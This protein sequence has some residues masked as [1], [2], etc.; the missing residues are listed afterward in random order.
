MPDGAINVVLCF[1][2]FFA[3]SGEA[4]QGTIGVL[5]SIIFQGEKDVS[6]GKYEQA[7]QALSGVIANARSNPAARPELRKALN[8]LAVAY[9]ELQRLSD[10]RAL[11]KEALTTSEQIAD[12]RMQIAVLNNLGLVLQL[13][14]SVAEADRTFQKSLL[15][16]RS[17]P[18]LK[19]SLLYAK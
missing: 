16:A 18:G 13:Q 3:T 10:A 4:A 11:L 12:S 9:R 8:D 15:K 6:A 19:Q 7:A 2:F 5:R 14:G 17:Q 1:V